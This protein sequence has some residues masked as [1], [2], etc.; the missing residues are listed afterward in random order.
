MNRQLAARHGVTAMPWQQVTDWTNKKN[1]KKILL[2]IL[3][4]PLPL[5]ASSYLT[6]WENGTSPQSFELTDR[7][8][9]SHETGYVSFKTNDTALSFPYSSSLRFTITDS[10]TG[11]GVTPANNQVRFRLSGKELSVSTGSGKDERILICDSAGNIVVDA[12][13]DT[14]GE[15]SADLSRLSR[16]IYL[17]KSNFS[18][19]KFVLR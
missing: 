3:Q 10:P 18:T 11:I 16:G 19:F 6:I 12:A 13:T 1:M 15:Y 4:L 14:N 8:V 17:F 2:L 9:V 7:A 5:L